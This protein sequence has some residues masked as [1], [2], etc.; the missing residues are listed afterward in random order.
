MS[1][2]AYRVHMDT[3]TLVLEAECRAK[4]A[5][6][7]IAEVCRRADVYQSTWTRWK[8]GVNDPNFGTWNKVMRVIEQAERARAA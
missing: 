6:L 3:P 1:K 8:R 5:G 7:S 4:A 2:F